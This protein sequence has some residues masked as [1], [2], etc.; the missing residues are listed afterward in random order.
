MKFVEDGG[1][2][3][4]L[5]GRQSWE[6]NGFFQTELS[7]VMPVRADALKAIEAE[8]PFPVLL[9]D[10]ARAHPAFAGDPEFWEIIPPLLS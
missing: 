2:L 4:L 5:G 10:T 7:K 6:A 8:E 9:T 3:V 1:S